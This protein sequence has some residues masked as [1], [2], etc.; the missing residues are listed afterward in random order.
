MFVRCR[1]LV[2]KLRNYVICICVRLLGCRV[3]NLEKCHLAF[4]GVI[5]FVQDMGIEW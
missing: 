4:S 2:A 5:F 1:E 3:G